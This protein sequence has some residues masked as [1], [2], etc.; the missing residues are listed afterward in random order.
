MKISY[1]NRPPNWRYS[2]YGED[3]QCGIT[4]HNVNRK[5]DGVIIVGKADRSYNYALEVKGRD[6]LTKNI[7]K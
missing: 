5:D 6:Y 4:I 1:M 7:L 3:D 2:H